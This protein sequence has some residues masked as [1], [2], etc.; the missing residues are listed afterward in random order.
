[1]SGGIGGEIEWIGGRVGVFGGI[2][3]TFLH[4]NET[5]NVP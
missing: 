1:M 3:Q 5:S 2:H 4:A